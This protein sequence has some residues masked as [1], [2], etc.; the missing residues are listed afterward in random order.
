[1][2]SYK[3]H[4]ILESIFFKNHYYV[5]LIYSDYRKKP[6]KINILFSVFLLKGKKKKIGSDRVSISLLNDMCVIII[7]VDIS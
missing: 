4:E 6:L 3:R 7:V 1:M 2:T 5:V